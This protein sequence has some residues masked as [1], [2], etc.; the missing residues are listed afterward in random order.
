MG[1][2]P[3]LGD[4]R[5]V[6][7]L[8]TGRPG[9]A[10]VLEA[11]EF[12][13]TVRLD[14]RLDVIELEIVTNIAVEIAIPGIAGV[15]FDGGPDLHA[16]L[17]IAAK[18]GGT[19]AGKERRVDAVTGTRIGVHDRVGIDHEPADVGFLQKLL[20]ARGVGALGEPDAAWVAAKTF[21]VVIARDEDLST[22]RFRILG[23]QRQIAVSRAASDDLQ[24]A[25]ILEFAER[26][27]QVLIVLIDEDVAAIFQAVEI[28]P[29]EFVELVIALGAVDFLVRELDRFIDTLDVAVLQQLIAQHSRERRR[30]RHGEAE[31]AAILQQPIHHVDERD[32]GFRNRL[33]KPILLEEFLVLGVTDEREMRVKNESEVTLWRHGMWVKCYTPR[34]CLSRVNSGAER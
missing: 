8:V 7:F 14:V 24:L 5:T 2:R 31:I 34:R 9:D 30:D 6:G 23:H 1:G 17:D 29:G 26:R 22:D 25:R 18:G 20:D 28:E 10:V 21:A 13:Q 33:V 16:R 3:L 15:A 27:E 4:G 12:A 11:G 19:G 32:I